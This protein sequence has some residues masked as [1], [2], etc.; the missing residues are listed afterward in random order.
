MP[1][2]SL[3][4]VL[5]IRHRTRST[6]AGGFWSIGQ[7][8]NRQYKSGCFDL[9]LKLNSPHLQLFHSS[10]WYLGN[11]VRIQTSIFF[12]QICQLP[13]MKFYSVGLLAT[14]GTRIHQGQQLKNTLSSLKWICISILTISILFTYC[15]LWM[16][17]PWT[18]SYKYFL[19]W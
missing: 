15:I 10:M 7:N 18:K 17:G 3:E 2:C 19:G 11:S 6:T 14:K 12:N 4:H 8:Y 16:T 5:E 1:H 9:A 13:K